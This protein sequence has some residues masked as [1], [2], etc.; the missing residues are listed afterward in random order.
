MMG[1]KKSF[2]GREAFHRMNFLYQACHVMQA[3]SSK[4]NQIMS[5]YYG[6]I[7]VGV[8]KKAVLRIDPS[9]K[10]NICKGCYSLL[11]PGKTSTV[12]MKKHNRGQIQQTCMNC[13]TMKRFNLK[14]GY[15]IWNEK[16]ESVVDLFICKDESSECGERKTET[17]TEEK[18]AGAA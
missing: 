11:C 13:H 7:M 6:H 18:D 12:H 4:A 15:N 8:A 2:Q 1:K 3:H 14:P 16:A 17:V 5:A 9:V 10:R